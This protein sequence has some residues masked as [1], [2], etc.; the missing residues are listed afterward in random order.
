MT[1]D[2][3][4]GVWGLAPPRDA[5]PRLPAA[6]ADTRSECYRSRS[7]FRRVFAGSSTRIL[8]WTR[9][10]GPGR[11]ARAHGRVAPGRAEALR[12]LA[13]EFRMAVRPRPEE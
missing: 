3:F 11:S 8:S 10:S 9:L 4:P 13:P 2:I 6:I 5:S 12:L 1:Q 7:W